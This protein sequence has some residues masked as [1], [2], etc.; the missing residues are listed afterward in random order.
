MSEDRYERFEHEY[1][2]V[3][4]ELADPAIFQDQRRAREV[5]RRHK[6]LEAIVGALRRVQALEGDRDAARELYRGASPAEREELKAELDE[7]DAALARAREALELLLLPSDPNDGRAVILEIR[8]AE[9]GEEANLFAKDLAD[10]YERWADRRSWKVEV[11]SRSVSDLGGYDDVTLL[12]RGDDAWKRL[13]HEAGPHRVQR[14]P[15]TETQGRVH[16]SSAT[17]TALPEADEIEVS[18][19]PS[20]LRIDVYRSTG[21]GGQSVNT[22][23]SAV[24]ITHLPTG[25][26]VAMQ[27]EKSQIQN[28]AKALQVLRARLLKLEQDKRQAE[29]TATRKAQIRSGGRSEKIRTY[30]FKENRVTDHRIGLTLYR[31]D[32]ILQGDLDELS[33][34]LLVHEREEQLA[35]LRD[36]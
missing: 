15:V 2:R 12:V 35:A 13:K 14:V 33:D 30:N 27:D 11:L 5:A 25:I 21:P 26:V 18:I 20:D 28:R 6:E 24:R 32:Q 8:G 3:L 1:A 10:M 16:T 19:D 9:G 31:L 36:A 22:T 17:V 7:I 29:L 34:A 4:E 23:D